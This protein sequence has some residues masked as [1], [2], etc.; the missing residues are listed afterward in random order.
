MGV[1]HPEKN[2]HVHE[3]VLSSHIP[4]A[5][6]LQPSRVHLD[7]SLTA[8][9]TSL[10]VSQE[11]AVNLSLGHSLFQEIILPCTYACQIIFKEIYHLMKILQDNRDQ[12]GRRNVWTGNFCWPQAAP[13][14]LTC[15]CSRAG[16][17]TGVRQGKTQDLLPQEVHGWRGSD[18]ISAGLC[19]SSSCC[20]SSIPSQLLSSDG[21]EIR[22]A[23]TSLSKKTMVS[24]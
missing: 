8:T 18:F 5:T 2:S 22:L 17:T 9:Q 19:P 23:E 24:I 10:P 3:L 7:R 4:L 15:P 12:T 21:L 13:P 1:S 6:R 11:M 20:S 16:S 14:T